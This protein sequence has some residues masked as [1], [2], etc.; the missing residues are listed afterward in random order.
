MKLDQFGVIWVPSL[1]DQ[2]THLAAS[3]N[4]YVS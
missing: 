3:Q 2:K 4:G 1:I